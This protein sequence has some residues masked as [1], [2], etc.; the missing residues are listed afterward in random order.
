MVARVICGRT[1]VFKTELNTISDMKEERTGP[2]MKEGIQYALIS[3]KIR[4]G[5]LKKK[6]TY[7]STAA[8]SQRL[9]LKSYITAFYQNT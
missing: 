3:H 4:K 8:Q 5:I 2:I 6:I 9:T 7:S 1:K